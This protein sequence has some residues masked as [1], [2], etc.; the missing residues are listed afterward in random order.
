MELLACRMGVS[1]VVFYLENVFQM[2]GWGGLYTKYRIY[3]S[4]FIYKPWLINEDG[5]NMRVTH[6]M[7]LLKYKPRGFWSGL[8]V[9][10]STGR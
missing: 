10:D 5:L 2:R 4:I 9:V 1:A 6:P 8:M 7:K 3:L